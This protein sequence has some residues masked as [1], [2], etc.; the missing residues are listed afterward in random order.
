V[1]FTS[2]IIVARLHQII[3]YLKGNIKPYIPP[4][5]CTNCIFNIKLP[6]NGVGSR[7]Y[8][9]D[10][11]KNYKM[12]KL[13]DQEFTFDVDMTKLPCGTNGALYFAEM[14]KD[15]GTSLYAQ[16]KA[17]AQ[18]GTGYCDAQCP[19]GL[20]FMHGEVCR[21]PLCLSGEVLTSGRPILTTRT[22]RAVMKWIFGKQ[23]ASAQ[24]ILHTLAPN[25]AIIDVLVQTAEMERTKHSVCVTS[26]AATSILTEWGTKSITVQGLETS[27]TRRRT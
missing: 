7:L 9:M 6:K 10:G 20:K 8:F 11:E 15:G 18:Y 17:G 25:Q 22:A 27:L 13:L 14:E 16:N 21:D 5:P 1:L 19:S 4:R 23:I 3:N 26:Q 12:F 2:T 24:R